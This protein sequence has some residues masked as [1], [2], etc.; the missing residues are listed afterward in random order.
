MQRLERPSSWLCPCQAADIWYRAEEA[1]KIC[2]TPGRPGALLRCCAA[3]LHPVCFG[4]LAQH[5]REARVPS[6]DPQQWTNNSW[7]AQPAR[8]SW[9]TR[10]GGCGRKAGLECEQSERRVNEGG[11][12]GR[13]V[14]RVRVGKLGEALSAGVERPGRDRS[15]GAGAASDAARRGRTRPQSSALS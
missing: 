7:S 14:L 10:G 9:E 12:E 15:G 8:R 6:F 1:F 2:V 11:E 3:S 5:L 4:S 13:G